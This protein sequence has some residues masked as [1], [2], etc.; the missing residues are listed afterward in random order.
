MT[1][2]LRYR[3]NDF[4][5]L[6]VTDKKQPE[7]CYEEIRKQNRRIDKFT[8]FCAIYV[9][10]GPFVYCV[11]P[12][13]T[14]YL[15]Y[16]SSS[17]NA[18]GQL[19]FDL[20]MEQEYGRHLFVYSVQANN[21]FRFFRFYGM[22][23]RTNFVH[24][25]IFVLLSLSAYFCLAILTLIK[26]PTMIIMMKYCALVFRLIVFQIEDLSQVQENASKSHK[27]ATIIRLHDRAFE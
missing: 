24:Y 4:I 6:S 3:L 17:Q 5:T 16:F 11:P 7:K 25:H 9:S 1:S 22:Q 12:L 14:S 26:V 27:L 18:S 23:I 8:K 21:F 10:F 13:T 19:R 2:L 20:P 15:R